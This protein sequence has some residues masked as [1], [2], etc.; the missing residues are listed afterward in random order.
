M[1]K[2]YKLTKLK[3]GL[4]IITK[5]MPGLKSVTV[6]VLVGAGSRYEKQEIR[7]LS[8]FLEHMFFKGAKKYKN[9]KEV[10]S[11][12]DSV[13]GYFNAFTGK[14]YA[15]YYIKVASPHVKVALDVL[16]DMLLYS[17]FEDQAIAR[18]H[19]IGQTKPVCVFR[20]IM[21]NFITSSPNTP[22]SPELDPSSPTS[23]TSS[24][25]SS[26]SSQHDQ[27]QDQDQD[28]DNSTLSID[29]YIYSL[30]EKKRSLYTLF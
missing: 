27:D 5:K 23:T 8:H 24:S 29:Q 12:V 18:A 14:E 22:T 6:L 10:A 30:Q 11:A 21:N 28:Q 13:G 2:D 19:R 17:R 16:S 7:G 25:P 26:T 4:N 9:P 15:G 3:N 1:A 20:F